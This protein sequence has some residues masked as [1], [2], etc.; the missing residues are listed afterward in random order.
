MTCDVINMPDGGRAFVRYSGRRWPRCK[1]GG[2]VAT[3]L[4]D[5]V[6]PGK[7]GRTCDAK[8]C[9]RCTFSPAPEFDLCPEHREAQLQLSLLGVLLT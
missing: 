7:G 5:F 2:S 3:L 4:C 6:L 9:A 1:C 8:L